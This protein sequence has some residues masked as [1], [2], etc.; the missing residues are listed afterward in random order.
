MTQRVRDRT[1]QLSEVFGVGARRI[2]SSPTR[3]YA[4]FWARVD[5]GSFDECWPYTGYIDPNGYGGLTRHMKRDYAH[6]YAYEITIGP[7]PPDRELDHLCRNR[8]CA[9]PWHLDPVPHKI[10]AWRG[11]RGRKSDCQRGHPF[12]ETNTGWKVDGR[13][14]CRECS[15]MHTRTDKYREKHRLYER[16]RRRKAARR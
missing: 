10:N 4:P 7:I 13:R 11:D 14:F 15:R 16:E 1:A 2:R 6:R 8:A 3:T 9:N 12:D 5:V